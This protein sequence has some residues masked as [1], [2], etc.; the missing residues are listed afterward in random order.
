MKL[1]IVI[2]L[3]LCL[4]LTACPPPDSRGNSGVGKE[5]EGITIT[6]KLQDELSV[7]GSTIEIFI[8]QNDE[9]LSGAQ[10]TV[11]GDMTHAGMS[12]VIA[13][14]TEQEKGLY[15]TEGF[16]FTMAGDWIVTTEVK[17]PGG[18]R[19]NDTVSLSVSR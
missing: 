10:V 5:V 6:T 4:L 15:L 12:P 17:L 16:E 7:G 3:V 8:T 19:V 18:Q 11:T 1:R 14:A 2:L 9:P 13:T